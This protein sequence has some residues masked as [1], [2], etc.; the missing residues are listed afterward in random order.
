MEKVDN[1]QELMGKVS[2]E[3]EILSIK[4]KCKKSKT[5]TE[6]KRAFY[7]LISSRLNTTEEKNHLTLRYVKRSFPN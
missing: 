3:M 1:M 7:G 4:R 5:L 6:M 2:R